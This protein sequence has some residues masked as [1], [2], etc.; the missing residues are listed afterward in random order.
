MG[1]VKRERMFVTREHQA[2]SMSKTR[3]RDVIDEGRGI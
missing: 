1:S 3:E 2:E